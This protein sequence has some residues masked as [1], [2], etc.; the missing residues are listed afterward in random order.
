ML[1]HDDDPLSPG[2]TLVKL[3][4]NCHFVYGGD[5]CDRGDGD[6]RILKDLLR[7]KDDA[8]NRVHF[9]LGNRCK[10]LVVK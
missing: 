3:R 8:P 5:V 4:N 2:G 7:L 10:V 9:I 1:Y 6:L